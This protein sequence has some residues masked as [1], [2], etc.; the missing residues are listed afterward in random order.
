[1]EHPFTCNVCGENRFRNDVVSEVFEI[2]GR[3]IL[4]ENIPAQVCLQCG[5]MTFSS[6]VAE[7]V[8]RMAC[9]EVQE[10]D[11]WQ[12]IGG[13]MARLGEQNAGFDEEEIR[14]DVAAAIAKVRSG[15]DE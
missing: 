11:V 5:E 2:N 6:E 14:A 8:R 7:S 15:V 1:M 4:I 10:T 3:R 12:R 9:G 13:M